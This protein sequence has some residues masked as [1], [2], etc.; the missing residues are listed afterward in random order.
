MS[1]QATPDTCELRIQS[2]LQQTKQKSGSQ[3]STPHFDVGD[4]L[5][6]L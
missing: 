2:F 6:R 1:V 3:E 5:W 4:K